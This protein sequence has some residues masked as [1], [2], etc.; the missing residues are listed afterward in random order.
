MLCSLLSRKHQWF[1]ILCCFLLATNTVF[2]LQDLL[3][4]ESSEFGPMVR[5]P[6][7]VVGA[8]AR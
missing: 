5:D 4:R 2:A 8:G 7:Y 3:R 6:F 1:V